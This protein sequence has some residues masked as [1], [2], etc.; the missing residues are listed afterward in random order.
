MLISAWIC[1]IPWQLGVFEAQRAALLA[2]CHSCYGTMAGWFGR[3]KDSVR[4]THR[5]RKIQF[6]SE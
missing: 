6:Q 5:I 4:T 3:K 1:F 2:F